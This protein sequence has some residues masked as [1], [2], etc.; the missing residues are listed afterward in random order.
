[1]WEPNLS[2]VA[3][4][5]HTWSYSWKLCTSR[6]CQLIPCLYWIRRFVARLRRPDSVHAA[7]LFGPQLRTKFIKYLFSRLCSKSPTTWSKGLLGK[8]IVIQLITRRLWDRNIHCRVHKSLPS[9]HILS[10]INS[11]HIQPFNSLKMNSDI[12][13]NLCLCLSSGL[14]LSTI[15]NKNSVCISHLPSMLHPLSPSSSLTSSY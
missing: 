12:T 4:R 15:S 14:S 2:T 13:L 6:T 7:G 10:H 5:T 3:C 9:V 11:F 1:L 8:L